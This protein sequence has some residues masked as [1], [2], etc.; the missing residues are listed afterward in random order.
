[1]LSATP[2]VASTNG[3]VLDVSISKSRGYRLRVMSL[4]CKKVDGTV[5]K[6]G[7]GVSCAARVVGQSNSVARRSVCAASSASSSVESSTIEALI[8]D[9][10][11]VIVE[12]EGIHREA[13][14]AAFQH[15]DVVC[16]GTSGPLVWTEEFYDMLQ[17]KVGGGKPKMRW[18]FGEHGWPATAVLGG[19]APETDADKEK[20]IDTIQDWKTE[21][22]K[23]I[24]E[25]GGVTARPGVVRIMDQAKAHG[26]PVAVC[27]AATKEAVVFVLESLLGKERFE[28]LDLFMAGDDVKAKKPDP[29]IYNEAAKRLGKDPST[30]LVIEDSL[31]GLQAALGAGMQ[32]VITYTGSTK[33]QEFP[34][35]S[36]VFKDMNN[37]DFIMLASGAYN[38]FD[39]RSFVAQ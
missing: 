23:D 31:I 20:I 9:C 35:S 34:G 16:P 19:A 5:R 33:E 27:S 14:N 13:Y 26:V 22:Y 8:F 24:I 2:V 37:I 28:G 4:Y 12:S 17:N 3:H 18:Y 10:D 36:A 21:K 1:M 39:T 32:C 38:G 6:K 25:H 29:L 11:G 7:M 30:C 15:F